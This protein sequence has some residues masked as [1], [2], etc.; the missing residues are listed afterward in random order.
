MRVH[1]T[2][3][4]ILTMFIPVK[5]VDIVFGKFC[6]INKFEYFYTFLTC[7]FYNHII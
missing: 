7:I 6:I 3:D 5:G 2:Q 1:I 4:D